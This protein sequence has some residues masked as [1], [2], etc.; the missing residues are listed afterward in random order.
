MPVFQ[1]TAGDEYERILCIGALGGGRWIEADPGP[2]RVIIVSVP[3]EKNPWFG[4]PMK[5]MRWG[6]LGR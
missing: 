2:M 1:L 3:E 6:I 5:V 4:Q